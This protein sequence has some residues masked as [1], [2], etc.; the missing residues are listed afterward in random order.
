MSS[1]TLTELIQWARGAGEILRAGY[2]KRHQVDQKGRID[3]V[4]EVDHQSEDYLV[5][6]IRQAYPSH[7]IFTEESGALSGQD[8]FCWYIDPV[9]GTTNYAHHLPLFAVSIAYAQD[10]VVQLGVVYNPLYGECYSAARGAGARLNGEPIHVS[11]TDTLL[12]SLLTTGFPYD[13]PTIEQNLPNFAHFA[14]L[15]Q[16]VRRLGSA[17]LDLCYVA[18]GR[19]DGYW[20]IKLQAYDMAAGALIAAEAGAAV[21]SLQGDPDCLK[22]PYG[23]LAANPAIH[24]LMLAEFQKLN[25]H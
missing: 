8:A 15:T 5:A 23:V 2:G 11:E 9:D 22:P 12:H 18:A 4:T 14:R 25:L 16:G 3:L 1:P 19:V 17:A 6:Q 10:G 20:E 24:A 21:T 13:M 7:K